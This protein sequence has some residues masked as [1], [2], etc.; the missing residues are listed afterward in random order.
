MKKVLTLLFIFI[1]FGLAS[2]DSFNLSSC[3]SC[4]IDF[5]GESYQTVV[6]TN[7]CQME[8]TKLNEEKTIAF[9]VEEANEAKVTLT[10]SAGKIDI[11]ISVKGEESIYKGNSQD[12]AEFK[13][14]FPKAGIYVIKVKGHN[15]SGSV[16]V[17]LES[18]TND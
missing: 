1:L 18:N 5:G 4:D 7:Y 17:E 10:H 8:Y 11:E 9:K 16:S 13:L 12:N 14:T 3:A 6:T 15:A 2:C